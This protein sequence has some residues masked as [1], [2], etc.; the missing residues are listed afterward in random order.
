MTRYETGLETFRSIF[1]KEQAEKS[2][3][4]I[5]EIAP[6][7]GR[8]IVE[9]A[10]GD[11]FKR[12]VLSLRDREV[13]LITALTTLGGV[14]GW[15]ETHIRAGLTAGLTPREIVEIIVHAS[16]PA[17]LPRTLNALNVA[18]HVFEVQK[19]TKHE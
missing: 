16:L 10:F 15:L 9:F 1:G 5:E 13:I 18:K 2:L 4:E 6:D 12:G 7:F 3:Q 17:G 14:E 11:I 19:I 8:H